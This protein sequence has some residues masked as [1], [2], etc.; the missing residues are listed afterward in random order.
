MKEEIDGV[1]YVPT[2]KLVALDMPKLESPFVRVTTEGGRYIVTP[3]I[4]EGYEWVFADPDVLCTEKI[5]GANVS[6]ML[7]GGELCG[8][9]NRTNQKPIGTLDGHMFIMGVRAA[10]ERGRVL[11]LGDGQ[12][13]GELMG[14]KIQGNFLGLDAPMWFPFDYLRR[15]FSYR[16]FHQHPKAFEG[17]S[18]WFK[19]G[20]F[21]LVYQHYHEGERVPPEGVVFYQPSTGRMA[22]LRRD[23]FDWYQG[24]RHGGDA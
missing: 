18:S 22:K 15:K 13:F 23:M 17:L 7:R 2:A 11:P 24:K 1:A 19:D 5:D 16:S 10:H 6:I 20:L 3:E 12:H 9:W 21:S 14:P 4:A 8:L